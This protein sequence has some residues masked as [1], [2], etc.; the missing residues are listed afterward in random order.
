[1]FK[2][3]NRY[4]LIEI[5]ARPEPSAESLIVLPEDYHAP[6]S[7]HVTATVLG[8]AEDVRFLLVAGT[9]IIVDRSMV[10]EINIRGTNYT[11]IL[12][13]YVVGLL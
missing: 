1:M 6:E 12:D 8:A 4:I 5:A 9:E 11:V 2:P 13:N 10:E 7:S 3:V